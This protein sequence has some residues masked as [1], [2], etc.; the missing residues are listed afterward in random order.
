MTMSRSGFNQFCPCG[1]GYPITLC[2]GV[3][4]DS[5]PSGS[6][7]PGS[8]LLPTTLKR[9]GLSFGQKITVE[10]GVYFP[11]LDRPV[12]SKEH[13]WSTLFSAGRS[14][15]SVNYASPLSMDSSA[16]SP[17][18]RIGLCNSEYRV[19]VQLSVHDKSCPFEMWMRDAFPPRTDKPYHIALTIDGIESRVSLCINGETA[20]EKNS[21]YLLKFVAQRIFTQVQGRM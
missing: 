2:C 17:D 3:K 10:V 4:N 16:A 9:E 20:C 18:L 19:I 21:F 7:G 12:K 14:F 11:P 5:R 15:D 6:V 13:P 1:S 8:L